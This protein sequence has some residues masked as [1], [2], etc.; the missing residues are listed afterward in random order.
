L[1]KD[2]AVESS[3]TAAGILNLLF[4]QLK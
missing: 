1:N 4:E 2:G 3:E